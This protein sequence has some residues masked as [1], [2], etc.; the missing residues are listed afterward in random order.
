MKNQQFRAAGALALVLIGLLMANVACY[1]G[2]VPGVLE[3]T[4]Y[5]T[6]TPLPAAEQA[7]FDVLDL[8]LAPRETGFQFFNMTV[9]PEPL[10]MP[11]LLN[12]DAQC[13]PNSP[14]T[15]LYAGQADNEITYYLLN[16]TGSVGWAAEERLV[17]PLKFSKNDLALTVTQDGQPLELLDQST[18]QPMLFSFTP[19]MPGTIVQVQD[20][21]A[22]D[23][24][25][26]GRKQILYLIECPVGNRGWVRNDDLF[27]PV[28]VDVNE[29]ALIV[30][31]KPAQF[32][33]TTEPA[34]T[35]GENRANG[36]CPPETI[37]DVQEA[38]L[39]DDIVYYKVVCGDIEGW[40]SQA[41]LVGPV[42]FQP[43]QAAI[44]YVPPVT[45]FEDELPDNAA[46]TVVD[47]DD[48]APGATPPANQETEETIP[49]TVEYVGPAY[50]TESPGEP[51]L[52]GDKANVV[53]TCASGEIAQIGPYAGVSENLYYRVE[54]AT[55]TDY[56]RKPGGGQTCIASE[57]LTGW[58]NQSLLK[59][60]LAF[61]PGQQVRFKPSSPAIMSGDDGASYARLP[62]TVDGAA[63]L[64]R[65]TEY[66]GRCPVEN[67][68]NVTGA[69]V[70]KSGRSDRFTFYYELQCDGQPG[71][72]EY[73]TTASGARQP[74]TTYQ[75]DV[76]TQITGIALGRDLERIE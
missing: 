55:C 5:A 25:E 31:T 71:Q 11:S 43:E 40:T 66:A 10:Q 44:I 69:F 6:L 26:D 52:E 28:K 70:Q 27:G 63:S 60:P 45:V 14:A 23:I 67:A 37:V 72:V 42:Q 1:S 68:I 50:L 62:V 49:Q 56:E 8:V 61:R 17:G 9:L 58:I 35:T 53:G 34:P 65:F 21:E 33:L 39:V 36:D 3:L 48:T 57:S 41:H 18:F 38:R 32:A 22:V 12:S 4:P 7:R 2:Q 76:A 64:G 30:S 16:C 75:T 20:I 73:Q 74:L 24:Y 47:P 13:Q 59:G 29:R 51:V 19:C 15:V 46:G 54:C